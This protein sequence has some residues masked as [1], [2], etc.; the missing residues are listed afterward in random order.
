VEEEGFDCARTCLLN[1]TDYPRDPFLMG[2]TTD[3]YPHSRRSQVR[4]A[5]DERN[6]RGLV[7]YIVSYRLKR[8][9]RVH[10]ERGLEI[11]SRRGGIAHLV[12]HSKELEDR[13]DWAKVQE[14]LRT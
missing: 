4:H 8:D 11:V 14:V 10:F 7:Q 12:I 2:M 9:W 13:D 1:R 5:L 3:A 6:F